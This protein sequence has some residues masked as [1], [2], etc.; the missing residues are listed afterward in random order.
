MW[1]QEQHRVSHHQALWL[2][3]LAEYQFRVVHIPGCAYAAAFFTRKRFPGGAAP[4][5]PTGYDEPDSAF[6][7]FTVSG[8]ARSFRLRCR[9]SR[10]RVALFSARRLRGRASRGASV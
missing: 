1:L 7:L 9:W 6:E 4:A 8:T 5:P 2:N 3:L 10:C